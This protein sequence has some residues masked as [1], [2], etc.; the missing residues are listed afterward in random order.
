M[1]H[2]DKERRSKGSS[3][4]RVLEIIEAVA[5][6]ERSPSPADLSFMLDI[7][8]PSMHRLLQQLQ[9]DGFLQ[10]NMRGLVVPSD[11]LH[12]MAMGVIYASRYK[13]A[14]Q[15]ILHHLAEAID[16]T[17]GI[18]LPDGTEMVYYDR[19]ASNWPLQL[20]LPVG[21][22]VPLWC[23]A[24]GKLYLST[25]A[26]NRRQQIISHL[27]LTKMARNTL[28]QPEA[29]EEAL[30]HIR[31]Q[32]FSTDNEEFVD[33]MVACAVPVQDQEGRT[34][35][36]LYTH[37]PTIRK[38]LDELCA[39]EPLLRQAAEKLGQLIHDPSY[40]GEKTES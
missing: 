26:K 12:K 11:R 31:E 13:A 17:C 14:R 34:F 16:E 21:S 1:D 20:H 15:A 25:F 33:G 22:R 24:S 36:C 40:L 3:I 27:P 5:Q 6:A 38:S 19:V 2:D 4:S 35:A 32:R 23:T 10:I 29:L 9:A 28:T 39:F 37:A 7:P 30:S 18:A 8:K